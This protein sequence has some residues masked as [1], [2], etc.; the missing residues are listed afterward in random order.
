MVETGRSI[1]IDLLADGDLS[2]V[3]PGQHTVLEAAS[4]SLLQALRLRDSFFALRCG[5]TSVAVSFGGHLP[6]SLWAFIRG[7][8]THNPCRVHTSQVLERAK[9]FIGLDIPQELVPVDHSCLV[10]SPGSMYSFKHLADTLD[11]LWSGSYKGEKSTEERAGLR[12]KSETACERQDSQLATRCRIW[13]VEEAHKL[14]RLVALNPEHSQKAFPLSRSDDLANVDDGAGGL[15]A[16]PDKLQEKAISTAI[17]VGCRGP[18]ARVA[19]AAAAMTVEGYARLWHHS[20]VQDFACTDGERHAISVVQRNWSAL[21]AARQNDENRPVPHILNTPLIGQL[22]DKNISSEQ[23]TAQISAVGKKAEA[24]IPVPVVGAV[25]GGVAGAACGGFYA[26]SLVRGAWR[27]SGHVPA[28]RVPKL[29]GAIGASRQIPF[30]FHGKVSDCPELVLRDITM[31]SSRGIFL[32]GAVLCAARLCLPTSFAVPSR[33]ARRDNEF[34]VSSLELRATSSEYHMGQDGL[35]DGA[36]LAGLSGLALKPRFSRVH[37]SAGFGGSGLSGKWGCYKT[38]G[39]IDAYWK[40]AG[41]PWL[42]RKGL[43]LMD[44]GAGKNQ[45]VREFA[46][47]A[48]DIEMEYS[49]Q[50]PGL[51]GLGFTE[52]YKVGNGVQEITR[53]GGAKILVDPVWESDS[54]LR[55][56]NMNPAKQTQGWTKSVLGGSKDEE[57]KKEASESEAAGDGEVIDVHRFYI[58]KDSLVLE[59]DS[60]PSGGPVVK[61][62]L[63]KLE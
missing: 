60:S 28:F 53:M 39:D 6:A 38:E 30:T 12:A 42:A 4:G 37:R 44:W 47:E 40:A 23:F 52:K 21:R 55:V 56:T 9:S 62:F 59:A 61:W 8:E 2:G 45:N 22:E 32:I 54:V 1:R 41:L 57:A 10:W 63:H 19:G 18:A 35:H 16:V 33:P 58:E 48:D 17:H 24:S 13:N 26:N 5:L 14:T 20:V 15:R 36:S 51:G 11:V 29:S 3:I 43:Q 27:L 34:K 25:I 49:F 31:G 50:G 46:Q 7:S